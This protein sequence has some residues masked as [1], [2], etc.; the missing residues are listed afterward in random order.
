LS[1]LSGAGRTE[2]R[3]LVYAADAADARPGS[4]GDPPRPAAN[5]SPADAVRHGI[6]LVSEHRTGEGLLL[7][8]SI[9]ANQSLGQL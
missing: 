4:I 6:A 2:W 9:A 8:Q 7:P 1:G 5:R 3:R